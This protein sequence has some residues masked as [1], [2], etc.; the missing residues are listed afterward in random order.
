M[1]EVMLA[2][3]FHRE[4]RKPFSDGKESYKNTRY[5]HDIQ[6]NKMKDELPLF[7]GKTL[8]SSATTTKVISGIN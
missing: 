3:D 5:K 6:D 2:Y 1:D 4:T 7:D 8:E